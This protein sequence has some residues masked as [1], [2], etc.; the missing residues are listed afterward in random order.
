MAFIHC[1][2]G[3]SLDLRC[4]NASYTHAH[5]HTHTHNNI[6]FIMVCGWIKGFCHSMNTTQRLVVIPWWL[7]MGMPD[8]QHLC[9]QTARDHSIKKSASNDND[10]VMDANP[11]HGEGFCTAGKTVKAIDDGEYE[12]VDTQTR[13]VKGAEIKIPMRWD[14]EVL[15]KPI[16]L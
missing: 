12:T 8:K 9:K 5:A 2:L 3:F 6:I 10:I 7:E 13:Q 4:E 11:V 14:S 15:R 16:T 1:W